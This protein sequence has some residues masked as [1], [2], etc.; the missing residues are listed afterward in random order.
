MVE[1]DRH[2][3]GVQICQPYVT[4]NRLPRS[5]LR[6]LHKHNGRE[7]L[8]RA[9]YGTIVNHTRHILARAL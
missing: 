7:L 9:S 6:L 4:L 3:V 2:C 1:A 5:D 8:V